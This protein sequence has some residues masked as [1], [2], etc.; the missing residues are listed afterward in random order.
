MTMESKL[1]IPSIFRAL[2]KPGV[3]AVL[4][5]TAFCLSVTA[6][7]AE[8]YRWKDNDGNIHYGAIVP[9]EYANRPYDVLN[10]VGIVI[11][12]VENT[13]IAPETIIEPDPQ[14][15]EPPVAEQELQRQSDRL[16][17]VKYRSE[18]AI[19]D[20]L[21]KGITQLGYESSLIN[22][23]IESTNTAI[24]D[25][26]RQAADQQ[27]ANL[28]ISID[29]QKGINRLYKRRAWDKKRQTAINNR[30]NQIRASFQAELLRYRTLKSDI[31]KTKEA[32]GDHG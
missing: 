11:K 22:Q 18:E 27:R 1:S 10:N 19:N 29:Q 31:G 14:L 4:I 8:T 20:A 2:V 32:Q 26:I 9:P 5:A 23:S 28:P 15:T 3:V 30:R 17:L 24:R 13:S 12:H 6:L 21:E 25:Q 7:A 16:L